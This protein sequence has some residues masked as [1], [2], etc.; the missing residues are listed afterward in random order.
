MIPPPLL[1]SNSFLKL[2]TFQRL[3]GIERVLK[4]NYLYTLLVFV[5]FGILSGF[6]EWN[7]TVVF[8]CNILA[9]VPLAMLLNFATEE[10]SVNAG[11]TVGVLLNATFGNAVEM[12]V[13]DLNL[14]PLN[15]NV[16][17]LTISSRSAQL[18]F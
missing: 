6:L 9:I 12:I 11:Q 8:L 4:S 7:P 13:S 14:H 1:R 10:L 16:T 3:R 17:G 5:P 2:S 15:P 18:L